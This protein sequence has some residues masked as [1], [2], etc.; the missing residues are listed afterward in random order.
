VSRINVLVASVSVDAKAEVIAERVA[1]RPDMTLVGGPF[2][3]ADKVDAFLEAS[4]ALPQIAV[5]LL[6]NPAE[7][8]QIAEQWVARRADLVVMLVDLVDDVIRIQGITLRDPRLD[9]L[10]TALREIVARVGPEARERVVRIQLAT[11]SAPPA[12]AEPADDAEAAT[13]P[14]PEARPLLDASI[15]WLHHLLRDAIERVPADNGDVHGLSITRTTLLESLDTPALRTADDRPEGLDPASEKLDAALTAALEHPDQHHEPLAVGARAFRLTPLEFRLVVLS[16]AP[17]IDFRFQR[18]I[19]FLLDEMGRRVGTFG[20]YAMLLSAN[21][22]V[23]DELSRTGTLDRWLIFDGPPGQRAAADEPLRVD[24]FLARW[25][26]GETEAL[27]QDPR[28]RRATRLEPWLGASLLT[29]PRLRDKARQIVDRLPGPD[30]STHG[31]SRWLLLD[32]IDSAGWRALI[33]VGGAVCGRAP[34]RVEAVRLAGAD[35]ADVEDHGR[36]VARWSRLTARPLIVNTIKAET[37]EGDDEWLRSFLSA[38]A[39]TGVSA[40]LISGDEARSVRLLGATPFDL[41]AGD[42]LDHDA[43]LEAIRAAANGADL[44]LAQEDARVLGSRYPLPV[45]GLEQAMRLARSRPLN[46]DACDPRLDRFSAAAKEL[47]AEGL[48]HLADRL[49]P[50][51]D[52]DD[53]VLPADRKAQL[54]E[55]VDNVRLAHQVLVDWK[56]GRRLPYG[57]GVTAMFFGLSG[58]GKTMAAMGI[59]RRLNIQILRL[60]LS[61]VVSKYIG[62]TEKNIDRVFTD[63]QRSGAAVLI[64][65]ADALLGKR[66]EVKDAHDRYANI[67]VAFLLQRMEA[68]DGLAILTTNMKQGLDP[69][70]LRRLRFIIDFPRPDA[71]ARERIWRQCLP[72]GSHALTN[73]ALRQL[74]RKIDVTGGH[75]RQITLRAAFLAAAAG[76]LITLEH[77]VQAAKAELAK[78]G[79]PAVE[80][81]PATGR[82]AA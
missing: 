44:W 8:R 33:E 22:T 15:N 4:P 19:G 35:L 26:L 29:S 12:A 72:E 63:A 49:E 48:S 53:V 74:A 30:A 2:M 79:M 69:A 31:T 7:T 37:A 40:A 65:E 77:V 60:D 18:C 5:I 39:S 45:D 34:I 6:G 46:Y 11:P 59:A 42:P 57:R 1:A 20:L 24:P 28:A 52:L 21:A 27:A 55:I 32:G 38:V 58:T 66:S 25:L 3:K 73:A 67:E 62:D 43:H 75:L 14:T 47:V 64:D 71:E 17:E 9:A 81:D 41:I 68:F 61:R 76:S 13:R 36:R 70:F 23:R 56:F 51:F 54:V 10:L 80:I 16:L 82:R 78:L 50:V